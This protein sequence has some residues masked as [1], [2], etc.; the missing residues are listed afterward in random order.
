MPMNPLAISI[1]SLPFCRCSHAATLSRATKK[2][3]HPLVTALSG[4]LPIILSAPHGGRDAVT[5]FLPG[6]EKV[7]ATFKL[8][9]R[10]SLSTPPP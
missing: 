2:K 5:V 10:N 9:F 1:I 3:S 8:P 7:C 6:R 4:D